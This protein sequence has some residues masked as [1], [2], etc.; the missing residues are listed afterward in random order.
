MNH[1]CFTVIEAGKSKIKVPT[2]SVSGEHPLLGLQTAIFLLCF[3][4]VE[5]REKGKKLSCIFS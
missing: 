5:S 4:M 2:D 1:L 3:N